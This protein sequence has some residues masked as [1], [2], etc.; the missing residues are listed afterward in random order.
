MFRPHAPVFVLLGRFGD[1]IQLAPCFKAIHDRTGERPTVVVSSEY[2]SVLE[3]VSYVKPHVLRVHWW[4]G[5]PTARQ[6][7]EAISGDVR[8][9]QWWHEPV[10]DEFRPAA[11][12]GGIVLQSHGHNF[13]VDVSKDPDYGTSMARRCGFTRE[14]WITLPLVFDRRNP[15]R[16]AELLKTVC[17]GSKLPLLLYNFQGIS[18]PFAFA[19]EVINRL[20]TFRRDFHLVDLSRIAA[21][22]IYDLLGLYDAAAGLLTSDTS[23]AHLAPASFIPTVW[24]TVDSWCTSVPKGNVALHV[25][26][27]ETPRRLDEVTAIVEGW[28]AHVPAPPQQLQSA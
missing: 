17:R 28:K 21:H 11:F 9:L 18:S 3:G 4:A 2:A 20:L 26:Y 16:E 27:N 13:G 7:A 10:A 19:P 23:T 22:R 8:V 5:V 12:T 6:V 24:F 25:K 14:E 15:V 1:L